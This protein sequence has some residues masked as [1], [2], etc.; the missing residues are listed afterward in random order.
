MS[1][2]D[3]DDS[4]AHARKQPSRSVKGVSKNYVKRIEDFLTS[5]AHCLRDLTKKGQQGFHVYSI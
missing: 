4:T 2:I 3:N 1:P 5:L